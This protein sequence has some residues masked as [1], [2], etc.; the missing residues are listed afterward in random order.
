MSCN[1]NGGIQ[2]LLIERDCYCKGT[3]FLC[4]TRTCHCN[5]NVLVEGLL[6]YSRTVVVKGLFFLA[7]CICCK[8]YVFP[9][10]KNICCKGTVFLCSKKVVKGLLFFAV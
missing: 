1:N 8:R 10:N 4:G 9:C 6:I 3:V 2:G 7:V 5:K